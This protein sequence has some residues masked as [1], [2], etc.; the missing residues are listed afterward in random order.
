[1]ARPRKNAAHRKNHVITVRLNDAQYELISGYAKD[2]GMR[3]SDYIRTQLMKGNV[4][5][6]YQI[7]ADFPEL[8][9][10]TR[11]LAGIGNNLNQIARYFNMRVSNE[12]DEHAC[13][14]TRRMP[15]QPDSEEAV[16]LGGLR[17]QAMQEEINKCIR[18]VMEI[19]KDVAELAGEYHGNLKTSE[20]S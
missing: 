20:K 10:V 8:Q 7:V 17:S 19:R 14:F 16:R 2:A 12:P 18:A 3:I 13:M 4:E 11:E 5:I 15:R 9:K 6:R 1:M